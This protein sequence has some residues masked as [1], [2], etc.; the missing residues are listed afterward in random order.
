METDSFTDPV[1][2]ARF[3]LS[4]VNAID[5]FLHL[6]NPFRTKIH[7]S[8]EVLAMQG[9]GIGILMQ[10]GSMTHAADE[11]RPLSPIEA[12]AEYNQA[13]SRLPGEQY[14]LL[15]PSEP[16]FYT[17]PSP[18][19]TIRHVLRTSPSSVKV[20]GIYYIVEGIIYKAPAVRSVM[21]TNTTRTLTGLSGACQSLSQCARYHP[22]VGYTWVF[23]EEEMDPVA[24]V[25]LAKKRKRRKILDSRRPGE[26]TA[27]EEE[28]IRA[29]EAM[30]QILV[31]LSRS[32]LFSKRESKQKTK[33]VEAR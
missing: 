6:L 25:Q 19:Y 15:P 10:Q 22:S 28:G 27:A 3:G 17:Q 14:E 8:N 2:L 29:S 33:K 24:L 13:L 18:L 31:R 21:K 7:T 4:R 30:D 5:Y 11:R 1:Y 12:E 9:I 20:L 32:P 16:S 26:R 23:E